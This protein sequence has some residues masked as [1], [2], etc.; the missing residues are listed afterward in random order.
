MA[1]ETGGAACLKQDWL[2]M[3]AALGTEFFHSV[4]RRAPVEL[5]AA[6]EQLSCA[7][8]TPFDGVWLFRKT[9]QDLFDNSRKAMSR[10]SPVS[11]RN[12]PPRSCSESRTKF[13]KQQDIIEYHGLS[14]LPTAFICRSLGGDPSGVVHHKVSSMGRFLRDNVSG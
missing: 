10:S 6:R 9:G 12:L 11:K 14:E 8:C 3:G 1:L 13:R 7:I 5:T 4:G 2:A